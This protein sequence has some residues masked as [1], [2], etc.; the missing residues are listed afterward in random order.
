MIDSKLLVTTKSSGGQPPYDVWGVW[1]PRKGDN[2]IFTMEVA[3]TYEADVTAELFQ[4]NYD[5]VGDGASAGVS[6]SFAPN[7][8]PL[9]KSITKTGAKELVRFKL[10]I[11]RGSRLEDD[12]I[13]WFL[14]RFLRPVWFETIKV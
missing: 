3:A 2:A 10:T 1:I 7:E 8:G 6:M 4:K 12:E 9:R 11:A 14:F 13:G 5:E